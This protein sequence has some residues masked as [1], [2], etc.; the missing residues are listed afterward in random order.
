MLQDFTN[1][2]QSN[3]PIST[4]ATRKYFEHISY[5]LFQKIFL[6]N[7]GGPFFATPGAIAPFSNSPSP[8]TYPH[9]VPDVSTYFC[10]SFFTVLPSIYLLV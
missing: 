7:F 8:A 9:T 6:Q 5:T 3:I 2:A 4:A 10:T 1:I